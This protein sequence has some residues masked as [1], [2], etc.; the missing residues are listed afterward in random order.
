MEMY[1]ANRWVEASILLHRM[2]KEEDSDGLMKTL[3]W[4]LFKVWPLVKVKIE[5]MMDK[6]RGQDRREYAD[7]YV[8]E[9]YDYWYEKN[10]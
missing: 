5:A 7:P 4:E 2:A 6:E 10:G 9:L 1:A 3:K 8:Q